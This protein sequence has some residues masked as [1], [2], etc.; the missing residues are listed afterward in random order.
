MK[1]YTTFILVGII[2]LLAA[3]LTGVLVFMRNQ[4]VQERAFEPLVEIAAMEP[5]SE[6]WGINF[7]NQYSTFMKTETN[8]I[9]TTY[10]GSSQFSWLERDPRQ[11]I[12]FA[13]YGFPGVGCR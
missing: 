4:P 5:D 6:K 9:D 13:G 2:I 12:L 3:V 10:A 7:P 1:K 11:V 8:N